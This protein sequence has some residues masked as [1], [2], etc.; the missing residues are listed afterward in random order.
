MPVALLIADSD[1]V[2]R[3]VAKRL[4]GEAVRVVGEAGDGDEAVRLAR[5][6]RPDVVL[7]DL[8][9]PGDGIVATQRIKGE[10]PETKVILLTVREEE[11]LSSTGK[12]GADALLAKKDVR[13]ELLSVVWRAASGFAGRWDGGERRGKGPAATRTRW[14]GRERRKSPPQRTPDPPASG[15]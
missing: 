8:G 10:R 4:L 9:L 2:L 12:T 11:Y 5:E 1:T 14:D 15:S 3:G 13:T 7:M 6:L